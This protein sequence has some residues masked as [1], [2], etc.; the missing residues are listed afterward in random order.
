VGPNNSG[1]SSLL[2]F[3][4]EMRP[5]FDMFNSGMSAHIFVTNTPPLTFGPQPTLF[6]RHEFF[7]NSNTRDLHIDIRLSEQLEEAGIPKADRVRLTVLHNTNNWRAT[8]DNIPQFTGPR[9]DMSISN[10]LLYAA[11]TPIVNLGPL[12]EAFQLLKDTLYIGPF[13]NA[14][15]IGSSDTYFDI[16][17]GQAFIGTWKHFRSGSQKQNNEACHQ[18]TAEIQDIFGFKSLDITPS[19]DD[20]SLQ[21]MINGR[22][23]KLHE[24][25][26]GLAQFLMVLAAAATRKPAYILIDEPEL[27]LH[28]ALQS[29]FLTTLGS[30][31]K[32]GVLFATHSLG[33]ARQ[34]ADTLYTVRNPENSGSS[35]KEWNTTTSFAEFLGEL[36]YSGYREMGFSKILFVEGKTEIKTFQE[37]LRKL[38][39]DHEFVVLSLAGSDMINPSIEQELSEVLRLSDKVFSIIDSEREKEKAPLAPSREGFVGVCKKLGIKCHVLTRRATENYFPESAVKVLGENFHALTEFE[40]LSSASPRWGKSQNWKI[41]R[42]MSVEDIA[43]TDFGQFLA[44]I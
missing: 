10:G 14:I 20:R 38:K 23:F 42:E 12:F 39:R 19:A 33:L 3:F 29:K 6:D 34:C 44:T 2:K 21:F 22:S 7:N 36:G 26:S 1:K 17:V 4:Y 41:A 28:P 15:N 13:R 35:I 25:G 30:Y 18:L 5:V 24:V 40:A 32:C 37:F 16:P 27:N 43:A 31:A 8:I 9:N 11:S